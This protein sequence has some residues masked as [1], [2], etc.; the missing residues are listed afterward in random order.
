[1]STPN[2]FTTSVPPIEWTDTGIV[3]PQESAI[4]VGVQADWN[5][6][7]GGN[8]NPDP[9]TPQGQLQSSQSAIIADKNSAIA[10]LVDQVDPDNST[11]FMQDAIGRIYFLNRNAGTSTVVQC[12]CIGDTGV[13]VPI[14]A[15]IIDTS[16]NIYTCTE[17]GTFGPSGQM[18]L[19]FA[20]TQIGPIAAPANT[21]NRIYIAING[22]DSVNN[23]SSGTLGAD[24][25]SP[26]DFEF[27]RQNSVAVNGNGSIP[28]IYGNVFQVS[29]VIDCF[30]S[31]NVTDDPISG[32]INNNP[33]STNY[34]LLP[35]SVYVAVTGGVSTAIAQAI[36]QKKNEGSNMNGNTTVQ[37]PDT[38]G[39]S[40][41][42]PVY[43]ITYNIAT[44]TPYSLIINIKNSA[45]LPSTIV[46]DVKQAVLAQFNGQTGVVGSNGV[47]IQ[48][49]GQRVRI[50][51][52][53]LAASFYGPVATCE[54]PSVPVSVLTI[55]LGTT[56]TGVASIA[57]GSQT[58]TV[59]SVS[60]GSVTPGTVLTMAGVPTGTYVVSQLSGTTGGAGSYLISAE[61]TALETNV[62]I[63]GVGGTSSQIGIDQQP[64]LDV[65]NIQV[66]LV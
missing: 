48:T 35:H 43:A 20:N 31:Q 22:W 65:S 60:A 24:V 45:A 16:N 53:F 18:T 10:Q 61:S 17:A 39:Y 33:N 46:T 32:A 64:T 66:N 14:G 52:L 8:L 49:S 54:G 50:G 2:P 3:L 63:T 51:S 25:E 42:Q 28:A 15:Q 47:T 44:A 40:Y 1:M 36:W 9:R 12:L 58:L 26:A 34:T 7:C 29:G 38:S 59:A 57:D 55:Y 13:T 19:S 21:V 23:A 41:P 4:L 30:V 56:F 37:V 5:G 27:R 62:A 11:G 6:A